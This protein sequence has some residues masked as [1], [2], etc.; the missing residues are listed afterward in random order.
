MKGGIPVAV[1]VVNVVTIAVGVVVG[2]DR[3]VVVEVYKINCG[4]S[5]SNTNKCSNTSNTI[6][7]IKK[8]NYHH[9]HICIFQNHHYSL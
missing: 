1:E 5:N 8:E 3:E 9:P 2:N 6:I 4:S 7:F